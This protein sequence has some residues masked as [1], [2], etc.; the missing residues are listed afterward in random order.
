MVEWQRAAMEIVTAILVVLGIVGVVSVVVLRKR[1]ARA[2]RR[3]DEDPLTT[4]QLQLRLGQIAHE[5]RALEGGDPR[6]AGAFHTR[7]AQA[8]YDALL[9]EACRRAG[10]DD[11]SP[12]TSE[13]DRL[14]RELELSSRGWSW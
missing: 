5:I 9:R 10:I 3:R 13:D 6:F 4:L 14:L 8:A 2:H 1:A 7:A 11:E 12:I